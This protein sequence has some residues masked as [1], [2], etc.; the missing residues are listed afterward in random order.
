MRSTLVEEVGGAGIGVEVGGG[1]RD[2]DDELEGKFEVEEL[3]G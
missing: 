2:G 3:G 1:G